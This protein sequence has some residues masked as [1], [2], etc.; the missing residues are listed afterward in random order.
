MDG[1]VRDRLDI[2]EVLSRYGHTIDGK[3]WAGFRGLFTEGVV[4]DYGAFGVLKGAAA[5]TAFMEPRHVGVTSQHAITNTVVDL[6]GDTAH[7]RCYVIATLVTEGG[8]F[9]RVGGY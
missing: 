3:D 8:P 9:R 4:G 6:N 2:G 7:T 1:D 5:L